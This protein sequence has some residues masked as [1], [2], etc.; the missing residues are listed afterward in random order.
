MD[1]A[2]VAGDLGDLLEARR[3]IVAAF[4]GIAAGAEALAARA[5]EADELDRLRAELEEER[6]VNAQLQERIRALR[7]RE[8]GRTTLEEEVSRLRS[9]LAA[10]MAARDSQRAELD[11]ILAELIPLV[12]EAR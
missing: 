9:E 3:R 4:E 6:T 1:M 11:A 8:T 5:A 12:E 7:D 10:L 2:V